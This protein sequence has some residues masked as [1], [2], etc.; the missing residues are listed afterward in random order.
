MSGKRRL[1]SMVCML[2]ITLVIGGGLLPQPRR[3]LAQEI[4]PTS[5][6]APRRSTATP[7]ATPVPITAQWSDASL[8]FTSRADIQTP[9]LTA[10]DTGMLHLFWKIRGAVTAQGDQEP[11]LLFYSQSNGSGWSPPVD[12]QADR[13]ILNPSAVVDHSGVIHL[14]WSGA[15]ARLKYSSA[16]VEQATQ[17][18]QWSAPQAFDMM[19]AAPQV[20]VDKNNILY[21]IY[22]GEQSRGVFLMTSSDGGAHWDSPL[23]LHPSDR[24]Y[25]SA[26]YP[27]IAIS[28]AGVLHVVWTEYQLPGGWPPTGI[29]Y[30]R[31]QDGGATW[32]TPTQITLE[33]YDQANI[34]VIGEDE[35]HIV[36][37]AIVTI[38]GRY[39]HWSADGGE[40]WSRRSVITDRGGTEGVPQLA[41]DSLRNLHVITTYLNCAR[42]YTWDRSGWSEGVCLDEGFSPAADGQAAPLV[43]EPAMTITRGRYLHTAYFHDRRQLWF[44][45]LELVNALTIA[46]DGFVPRPTSSSTPLPT[47]D[48]RTATLTTTAIPA[49]VYEGEIKP[50]NPFDRLA[51]DLLP[52]V[53][54]LAAGAGGIV[55]F[56]ALRQRRH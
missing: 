50:V 46:L 43:E 21:V 22:G 26:E 11:D 47:A 25:T 9:Y 53:V 1:L 14:V 10:D 36:Y 54:V 37:N 31:S 13:T 48:I 20:I 3:V 41:V 19:N 12:I 56:R 33:N 45:E 15:N 8:L 7:T 40:S 51:V 24:L 17:A 32:T 16:R 30:T 5:T 23:N 49:A 29:F 38:G 28:P 2:I 55:F 4:M 34:A 18:S 27:R 6:R 42:H 52:A 39:H 35:V 44:R